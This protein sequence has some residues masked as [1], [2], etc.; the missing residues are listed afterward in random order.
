MTRK[1]PVTEVAQIERDA[2]VMIDAGHD[3]VVIFKAVPPQ[4]V[5]DSLK[6]RG[7][8]FAAGKWTLSPREVDEVSRKV[9]RG[10]LD[11]DTANDLIEKILNDVAV[12]VARDI[13]AAGLRV[14]RLGAAD[15]DGIEYEVL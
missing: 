6:A 12:A 8:R 3:V 1:A 13:A 10:D 2:T 4:I 11:E 5:R 15:A 9:L 7:F 14:V